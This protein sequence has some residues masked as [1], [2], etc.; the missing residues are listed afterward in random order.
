MDNISV[1]DETSL[2]SSEV[3]CMGLV[4]QYRCFIMYLLHPVHMETA[5]LNTKI[6]R[7]QTSLQKHGEIFSSDLRIS[8]DHPETKR[9]CT[10][11]LFDAWFSFHLLCVDNYINVIVENHTFIPENEK[12]TVFPTESQ[13]YLQQF[14]PMYI[15]LHIEC[16]EGGNRPVIVAVNHLDLPPSQMKSWLF[17]ISLKLINLTYPGYLPRSYFKSSWLLEQEIRGSNPGLTAKILEISCFQVAIWLKY[18]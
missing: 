2:I 3:E 14:V 10:E 12:S 13:V 7:Y 11:S 8:S 5:S 6:A 15:R 4:V 16:P 1:S 17:L 9:W 18:R